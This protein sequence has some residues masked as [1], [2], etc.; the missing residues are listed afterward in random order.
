MFMPVLL[1][2]RFQSD[3]L[4]SLRGYWHLFFE[5]NC[6]QVSLRFKKEDPLYTPLGNITPTIYLY[7]YI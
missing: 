7:I 2:A 4:F 6:H 3:R 1:V 5:H